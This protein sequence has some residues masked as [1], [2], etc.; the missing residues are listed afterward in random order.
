M[1]EI[2]HVSYS[3]NTQ[4]DG[5]VLRDVSFEIKDGTFVILLGQS[6]SGKTTLLNIVAGLMKP[7]KG[8]II[9]DGEDIYAHNSDELCRFRASNIGFVF[10]NYFLEKSFS[11]G[12]N[13]LVPLLLREGLREN[14]RKKCVEKALT[15]VRMETRKDSKIHELSGGECQRVSIARAI[16]NEPKV[17]IAD[18]PTGN[19]DSKN[20]EMIIKM[21]KELTKKGTTV[22]MVTHNESYKTYADVVLRICDGNIV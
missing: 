2:Q 16:V 21:L 8:K 13:V 20:G 3:Y 9:Y 6:G 15:E 22:L 1:I 7:S 12:E 19:L 4:R 17:L 11:A 14:E 18:E 5:E 10:Q